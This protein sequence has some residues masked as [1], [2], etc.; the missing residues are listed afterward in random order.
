MSRGAGGD[1]REDVRLELEGLPAAL[2]GE[3]RSPGDGVQRDLDVEVR[4]AHIAQVP[5]DVHATNEPDSA[6]VVADPLAIA[7]RRPAGGGV[8]VQR[9][10]RDVAVIPARRDRCHGERGETVGKTYVSSWRVCPLLW[11]EKTV[12]QV[13]VSSETW[14]SKCALRIS[15]RYQA[16]STPP[17]SPTAPRS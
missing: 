3:D 1:R 16:M 7:R 8:V 9:I 10:L 17:M 5:G 15:P 2:A 13:T 4:A 6:E 11:P 12:V 14:M